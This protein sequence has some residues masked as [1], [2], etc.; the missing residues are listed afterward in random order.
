MAITLKK[1]KKKKEFPK[2]G[3]YN[4]FSNL[5]TQILNQDDNFGKKII[6]NAIIFYD[7]LLNLIV[8]IVWRI[9][10]VTVSYRSM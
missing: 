7:L 3:I 2:I 8:I 6:T 1:K 10:Y 9:A 5:I 4:F